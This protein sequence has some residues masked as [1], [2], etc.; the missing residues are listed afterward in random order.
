M[1]ISDRN[2]VLKKMGKLR[3]LRTTTELVKDI[4]KGCPEARNSDNILY[5]KVCENIGN[6]KGIDIEKMSMPH[7]LLNLKDM[8]LP[9]IETVGRCRRK[10]VEQCPE[11]AGN[12]AVQYGRAENEESF[13]RYARGEY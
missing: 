5:I 12:D 1:A 9:S 3:E 6:E 13:K 4:L 7:F 8:G 11:L 2:G 10:I